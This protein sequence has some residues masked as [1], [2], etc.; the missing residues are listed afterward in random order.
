[1]KKALIAAALISI[2]SFSYADSLVYAGASVGQS[3]LGDGDGTSFTVHA[4]TGILPFIGIEAGIVRSGEMD[5]A[6]GV[7]TEITSG[8]AAIKPSIDFGPLHI[9]AKGGLHR[10]DQTT[11]VGSNESADEGIDIMYGVGAE[12]FLLG[13]ISFG[14]SLQTYIVDDEELTNFTL[15]GTFHFL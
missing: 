9:Y 2:S 14:A 11:T 8:Y 7:T 12:Y 4:G 13:P 5:T 15:N 3:S 10:W 1:M 6:S